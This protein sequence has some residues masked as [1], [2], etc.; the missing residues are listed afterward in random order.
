MLGNFFPQ[1][2]QTGTLKILADQVRHNPDRL[3]N[4]IQKGITLLET[5]RYALPFVKIVLYIHIP[6]RV[7][8]NVLY[9]RVFLFQLQTVC[10][11]FVAKHFKKEGNCRFKTTDPITSSAFWYLPLQKNSQFTPEFYLA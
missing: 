4:N 9:Y 3:L 8:V 10:N 6:K 7:G 5:G 2:A 11:D 1:E